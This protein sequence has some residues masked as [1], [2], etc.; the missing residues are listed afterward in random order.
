MY[1]EHFKLQ[2]CPFRLAPNAEFLYMSE[3]LM[4]AK[5]YLNY[6]L[7]SGE[8]F[9]VISG[10]VGSGKT[11]L[12]QQWLSELSVNDVVVARVFQTR[13]NDVEF[14]QAVL[15]ELGMR[16]FAANKVELMGMLNTYLIECSSKGKPL[17]LVIDDAHNLNKDVFEI[18]RALSAT[19]VRKNKMLPVILI[20]EPHL[21]E[22]LKS[23]DMEHVWQRVRLHGH[24]EPLSKEEVAEYI[25]HRLRIAGAAD[26]GLF[27]ADAIPIIERY[28][29]GIP[30]LIN[31][32]CDT[33]LVTA[34]ADGNAHVTAD[35]MTTAIRELGWSP[36][37]IR[38]ATLKE[39]VRNQERAE[40]GDEASTEASPSTFANLNTRMNQLDAWSSLMSDR[41]THIESML[42]DIVAVLH[43][44]GREPHFRPVTRIGDRPHR[45][46]GK[47]AE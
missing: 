5:A 18:L 30:R 28:T 8:G 33:A 41:M 7:W 43:V 10:E 4:R 35:V 16:P 39:A 2:E 19:D 22:L 34:Y 17:L 32:L 42:S 12:T 29:G 47:R 20:G 13:L 25:A 15:V 44:D 11:L 38:K 37:A 27:A 40:R 9:I 6:G 31:V 23:F 24:I 1:L 26:T 21:A 45:G 46:D 3:G 36:Y 14:L